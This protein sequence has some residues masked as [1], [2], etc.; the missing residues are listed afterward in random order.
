MSSST[1]NGIEP[2]FFANQQKNKVDPQIAWEYYFGGHENAGRTFKRLL[3]STFQKPRDILTFVKIAMRH[4]KSIGRGHYTQFETD[5]L[6]NPKFTKEY[7][8]Y[9]LG[10]VKNYASFYMTAMDFSIY[11]KIFQY[12]DGK[13]SFSMMEF[14]AAFQNFIKWVNGEEVKNKEFLRDSE[15]L[16]QFLYEV[17]VIGYHEIAGKDKA[18]FYH[19]AYRERSINN[20]SPKVKTTG[21]LILNPGIS[22]ALDIGKEKSKNP[23]V[24]PISTPRN[25]KPRRFHGKVRNN[26]GRRS[27]D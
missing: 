1:Q 3:K 2:K 8:D 5:I 13:P 19:W 15:S 10:E 26:K 17:N 25:A 18:D 11:L 14:E 12:L 16:L 24:L 23:D 9:L 4:Q 6:S 20:L 27:S 7:S 22:K 21:D